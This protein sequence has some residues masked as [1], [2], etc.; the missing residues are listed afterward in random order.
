MPDNLSVE[1]SVNTQKAR[2]DVEKFKLE[3]QKLGRDLREAL[4]QGDKERAFDIAGD[5]EKTRLQVQRLNAEL[6]KTGNIGEKEAHKVELGIFRLGG[7][8]TQTTQKMQ[9]LSEAAGSLAG[10]LT[11][12]VGLEFARTLFTNISKLIE[13]M[14]DLRKTSAAL[15][16]DPSI[17]KAYGEAMAS[18]GLQSQDATGS[19]SAF[20]DVLAGAQH[21]AQTLGNNLV[22]TVN[23][24]KGAQ[25]A[26][27]DLSSSMTVL[28]GNLSQ[29]RAQAGAFVQIMRGSVI[30]GLNATGDVFERIGVKAKDFPKTAQGMLNFIQSVAA[31]V[32]DLGN[33]LNA[34]DLRELMAA[35]KIDDAE[36]FLKLM[37]EINAE[38]LKARAAKPGN[39]GPSKEDKAN[40]EEYNKAVADMGNE[41][42][43]TKE[44][45][46]TAVLPFIALETRGAGNFV[47]GLTNQFGRIKQGFIELG[48]AGGNT[49]TRLSDN[50]AEFE[51]THESQ[52]TTLKAAWQESF[53]T[54]LTQLW[55][56][57]TTAL[58]S[59]FKEFLDGI[60]QLM[61]DFTA[62][63][64]RAFT[65]TWDSI[66]N[67]WNSL[68]SYISS[69]I[70]SLSSSLGTIFGNA[71]TTGG[72]IVGGATGGYVRGPG[73]ST[74]DSILARLSRGEFVMR[75]KA[76]DH[77][78]P[79]F[80][81]A[82]NNLRN[83]LAGYSFGGLVD[84]QPTLPSFAS[85][86]LVSGSGTPVI[87]QLGGHSFALSGDAGVVNALVRET[88][89]ATML[90]A[91]KRVGIA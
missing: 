69:G 62:G 50:F 13:P 5:I 19:L 83:P 76:V 8:L 38:S 84:R 17:I 43:R 1:I 77:F 78:G 27:T 23:V 15:K 32:V 18:A 12:L 6:R 24:M 80:M 35:F 7:E 89:R 70:S 29:G 34:V 71:P 88:R 54:F 82:I 85:G 41:W 45:V 63:L 90:S 75:A 3:L 31:R 64:T 73:T 47:K 52:I 42:T 36:A 91:G 68:K 87:L 59:T 2:V 14:N 55:T 53:G 49:W 67:G 20:A 37:T 39:L 57:T 28:R 46:G 81:A 33:D 26:V 22:P 11:A 65:N 79:Q 58:N 56:D 10:G 40:L 44:L 61:T 9:Y 4:K 25:G 66:K 16:L 72:S 51:K 74:S 60:T 30:E 21:D 86:G 48:E